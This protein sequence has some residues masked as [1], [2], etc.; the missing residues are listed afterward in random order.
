MEGGAP[1]E[2]L[3]L[4]EVKKQ[5]RLAL[6]LAVACF[7]QKIILTISLMFVGHLGE[8]A[9]A[10]ASLATSFA[11][12]T[13]F[14]LMMGMSS[15]LDTLCGQAFGA[16]QHRLV[17]VYKQRAMLVLGLVSIP[18]AVVWAFAGEILLLIRQDP[19]IAA[20]AG[21]YVRC[22]IPTL[23]LF[24]QLQCY[25]RFL[26]S[27]NLV[28]P[29][30][31]SSGIT[32]ALH[33][34][35]CWLLVRRLGLGASGASLAIVVSNFFNLSFLAIYVRLS[36]SC[37]KT[38]LGFSWEPFHGILGFM[39]L[40]VP[41]ALMMCLECWAFELLVLLSG[42]LPNPKLET[43]VLS[44]CF[45]TYVLAFM[46]P[47]G[48]GFAVSIRVSNELGAGRAQA[49]RLA[50]RVAMLLSFSLGLFLALVMVLS[51]KRLGYV[52]SNVE[53]VA[54]YF[55]KM[56]PILAVCF[57]FDSM[58]S[59]LSG[60]VRG[61]GRQNIGAFINLPAYYV[62]GI[63]AATIF[64]FFCHLR[65]KGLWFGIFCGVTVQMLLFLSITLCTNWNKEAS[66]AKDRVFCSTSLDDTKTSCT[67]QA[68][69]CSSDG[70]VAQG[71][72]QETNYFVDC[73][74]G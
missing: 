27:Q 16:E 1:K 3:A 34:A 54:M 38:R 36:P 51:R 65:G 37:K 12:A 23:F 68:N 39:K 57:L 11:G 14:Y 44:I 35:V 67:L 63:P 60:I 61:C 52:Y 70:N 45:N 28:V 10:G 25:V 74:E 69:G 47:T 17:G 48:L 50:T 33:V 53:E 32:A 43:A 26:Q 20:R 4:S 6:P 46:V 66:K 58:N 49:A 2:S 15:C 41:S 22:M 72:T 24:G 19:E 30:M 9:L 29:V 42:L 21:S 71:T 8:L 13:G 64:A 18:V 5:L 59:V 31:L 62:V 73:S 55:S 7:L 40:A 56:M